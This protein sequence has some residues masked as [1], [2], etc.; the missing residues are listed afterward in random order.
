MKN[1]IKAVSLVLTALMLSSLALPASAAKVGDVVGEAVHTDIVTYINGQPVESFNINWETAVIVED[2]AD[3]GFNVVWDPTPG[4]RQLRVTRA[5]GKEFSNSFK[6]AAS[7]HPNGSHAFDVLHTDIVTYFDGQKIDS[8]NVNGRTIVYVD[9]INKFYG[10]RYV[11]DNDSR[12][13]SLTLKDSGAP[14]AAPSAGNGANYQWSFDYAQSETDS[15]LNNGFSW[16]LR[17]IGSNKFR[18][19]SSEGA[20]KA[21]S[22]LN[23]SGTGVT[24][25]VPRSTTVIG[26]T[27]NRLNSLIMLTNV[28][29]YRPVDRSSYNKNLLSQIYSVK[30]NGSPASGVLEYS[31][32]PSTLNYTFTFDAPVAYSDISTVDIAVG[33]IKTAAENA[34]VVDFINDKLPQSYAVTSGGSFTLINLQA[35]DNSFR[36]PRLD[37]STAQA[38]ALNEQIVSDFNNYA[39]IDGKTNGSYYNALKASSPTSGYAMLSSDAY[40]RRVDYET[41]VSDGVLTIV[42]SYSTTPLDASPYTDKYT[43]LYDTATGT[44][45]RSNA[46]ERNY[47]TS[48][49]EYGKLVSSSINDFRGNFVSAFLSGDTTL[50]ESLC[51]VSAGLYSDYKSIIFG[52]YA[53]T[54]AENGDYVQLT[55]NALTGND[56]VPAGMH[57]W[58]IYQSSS[59]VSFMP[60]TGSAAQAVDN[61]EADRAVQIW[62]QTGVYYAV[63]DAS[64]LSGEELATYKRHVFNYMVTTFGSVS[65]LTLNIYGQ[66]WFGV[67]FTSD[68]LA[69]FSSSL[70]ASGSFSGPVGTIFSRVYDILSDTQGANGTVFVKVKFYA[71]W[72]R[73]IESDTVTFTLK[74]ANV[75]GGTSYYVVSA[76]VESSGVAP[77]LGQ[78]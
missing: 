7:A 52:R 2:L 6:P 17:A 32:D 28:P 65:P 51:G 29:K 59:Y 69:E 58:K 71:D 37:L 8:F 23:I 34:K 66:Q 73:T 35:I 60:D 46:V 54:A 42:V 3:Y 26:D 20:Y 72:S 10:S 13:L 31:E 48:S 15:V 70:D 77:V 50:L 67:N 64:A 5:Y 1:T 4:S 43:Y 18:V 38:D 41:S 75:G 55:F 9:D 36:L 33:E 78:N 11:Y 74:P 22:G 21:I 19:T 40:G 45:S 24:F 49:S 62:L 27:L 39:F 47:I 56:S 44:W 25:S 63:T 57:T 53:I 61:S 16:S 14:A 12:T 30:I 68:D 76:T